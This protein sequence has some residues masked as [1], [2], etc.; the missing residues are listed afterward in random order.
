MYASRPQRGAYIFLYKCSTYIH[1][2]LDYGQN[3]LPFLYPLTEIPHYDITSS[4]AYT[5]QN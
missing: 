3:A 2:A 1:F 5:A 4:K